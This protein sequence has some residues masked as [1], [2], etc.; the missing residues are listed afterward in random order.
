[1]KQTAS[2]HVAV[3]LANTVCLGKGRRRRKKRAAA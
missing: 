2:P 3:M 1:M